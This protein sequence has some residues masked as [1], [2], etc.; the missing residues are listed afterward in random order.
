MGQEKSSNIALLNIKCVYANKVLAN[1]IDI[2]IDTFARS[3]NRQPFILVNL[4]M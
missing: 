1:V 3:N 2:V 4:Y